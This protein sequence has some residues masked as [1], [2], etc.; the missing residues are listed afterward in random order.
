MK[1]LEEIYYKID[2]KMRVINILAFLFFPLQGIAQTIPPYPV[3]FVHGINSDGT[4]FKSMIADLDPSQSLTGGRLQAAQPTNPLNCW[5]TASWEKISPQSW[6]TLNQ[7]SI[8]SSKRYFAIDFS[9]NHNLTL[10]A[11]GRELKQVIECVKK[12]TSTTQSPTTK[13]IIVAHSMGGLAAREYL[14]GTARNE[15]GWVSYGDDVAKLITIGTPHQGSLLASL[16]QYAVV[17]FACAVLQGTQPNNVGMNSLR[18][19]SPELMSLNDVSIVQLP[20]SNYRSIIVR[21]TLVYGISDTNGDGVVLEDSQDLSLV[22]KFNQGSNH[23]SILTFISKYSCD[24]FQVHACETVSSDVKR[25]VASEINSQPPP[26]PTPFA[27]TLP[28][29]TV[30]ITSSQASLKGSVYPGQNAG[31]TTFSTRFQWGVTTS[32]EQTPTAW[33]N[34]SVSTFQGYVSEPVVGLAS[35]T[36]YYYRL[37]A[38]NSNGVSY[39]EVLSFTTSPGSS[40]VLPAPTLLSPLPLAWNQST[41]PILSWSKIDNALSYRIMVATDPRQLPTDKASATC[42]DCALNVT[43]TTLSYTPANG[44]LKPGALY[45]WQVKGRGATE[46]GN[47]SSSQAFATALAPTVPLAQPVLLSPVNGVTTST[48]TPT[49]TWS[50]VPDA[51]FYSVMVSSNPNDLTSPSNSLLCNLCAISDITYTPSYQT[52]VGQLVSGQTYYWQVKALNSTAVSS[53]S[54]PTGTF[55][56]G[57]TLQASSATC[58]SAA[59]ATY[60][61]AP[62]SNLC[63][64]GTPS[65]LTG[66]GPWWWSCSGNGQTQNCLANI[67]SYTIS[68]S[69]SGNGTISPSASTVNLGAFANFTVAPNVGSKASV[70][71]CGIDQG[72]ISSPTVVT[73]R[74]IASNCQLTVT[75]T[76]NPITRFSKICNSGQEAGQ[77]D[78]P[79]NPKLGSNPTDWACTRD[80]SNGLIWEVKTS[81]GG[82]RDKDKTYT[83]Y[84]IN[85][86]TN[87]GNA[88]VKNGG[89]CVGSRCDTSGYADS[90]AAIQLCGAND[91]R[92]PSVDEIVTLIDDVSAN[93]GLAAI[94]ATFFPNSLDAPYWTSSASLGDPAFAGEI[95]FYHDY[96]VGTYGKR[97]GLRLRSVRGSSLKGSTGLTVSVSGN[98]SVFSSPVGIACGSN[99]TLHADIGTS[100]TLSAVASSGYVF[101]GWSG[102]CVGVGATCTVTLGQY[103]EV[104]ALFTT[105]AV[106]GVCGSV[107]G[108]YVTSQPIFNLCSNGTPSA[109]TGSGPWNWSC[110]G[111]GGG[112]SATCS[113]Y[114]QSGG[115]QLP[116]LPVTGFAYATTSASKAFGI[117]AGSDGNIW[118]TEINVNRIGRITPSG[119][120][121]EFGTGISGG[122]APYG[123]TRGPDGNLWF[124]EFGTDRIGRITPTGE[125][126]EYQLAIGSSPLGIVAGSDGNLWYTAYN[127]VGRITTNGIVN[128]FPLP[129]GSNPQG[130]AAGA[131]GNL[132]F[133]EPSVDRIGRIT[134]NGAITEFGVGITPGSHPYGIT[135]GPD[136]NVWFTEAGASKIG[137]ITMTGVVTEY[138]I[139]S[140]A[141][142]I[143]TGSDNNLW[144]IENGLSRIGRMTP[145][146]V[147]AEFATSTGVSNDLTAGPDG[148]LW[149]TLSTSSVIGRISLSELKTTVTLG[150]IQPFAAQIGSTSAVQKVALSNTGSTT[151]H[152]ASIA[153]SGDFTQNGCSATIAPGTSCN[154]R[155]TFIPTALG[156]RIGSLTLV[157][158]AAGSPHTISL[159][160]TGTAALAPQVLLNTTSLLFTSQAIGT[161]SP[162]QLVTLTNV[163]NA[164]LTIST[165]TTNGDF[166]G[167]GS[168]G[169][170]TT[171][172]VLAVGQTCSI[173]V[174]FKP[175]AGGG[176]TGQVSVSSNAPGGVS[177]VSLAGAGD[178]IPQTIV[179]GAAPGIIAGGK[180]TVTATGGP[181][182]NAVVFSSATPALCT[183]AGN[184][185]SGVNPGNCVVVANQAG[186]NFYGAAAPVTQAISIPAAFQT[187]SFATGWN[188]VGQSYNVSFDVATI[189]GDPN[190]VLS[191]WKWNRDFT[192]P[193]NDSNWAFYSPSDNAMS[194]KKLAVYAAS[195]GYLPLIKI[196]GGDGYW[197]NAKIPFTVTLPTGKPVSVTDLRSLPKGWNL[198]ATGN[199]SAPTS[200]NAELSNIP[201]A[202]GVVPQNLTSLWVWDVTLSKWFFYSSKLESQGG[203]SLL[204]YVSSKG[205]V[206]FQSNG[207]TLAPGN[208]F[209]LNVP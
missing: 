8:S 186:N 32:L 79:G 145:T 37:V 117:T 45:W 85:P 61:S 78:C 159:V 207:K 146:G 55:V 44:I 185:V 164:P 43:T 119:V 65:A 189:F 123:I 166:S 87:G 118:F 20:Q 137:R 131:D 177:T 129:F 90:V 120:V 5:W 46:Y 203:S 84:D 27:T 6:N 194:M 103:R 182:G 121:T 10:S 140:T 173:S 116:T 142:T 115:T 107:N 22:S 64:A 181:S 99:C 7:N 28:P 180:G 72:W 110:I 92:I 188:L 83:W 128:E 81:D 204:D 34:W 63:S 187:L 80:N 24:G 11:Q 144:F 56:A 51:A 112:A 47:W 149:F 41:T 174:I 86:A 68:T 23:Q 105:L 179:F 3:I 38:S 21:Q 49:M 31:A 147:F 88:G 26:Q 158:D 94:D 134:P 190:K 163:G 148:N 178:L 209:W 127:K 201:P 30:N 69:V 77:G 60:L 141:T 151:L 52:P 205:F 138:N 136:G 161:S 16:C 124:T 62:T 170:P 35:N 42:D 122:A 104:T 66:T 58:G 206:D 208:G 109:V 199:Q 202:P 18:P 54:L 196:K 33:R 14:Q 167:V 183:V 100:V 108:Q 192:K 17:N 75:F 176:R 57:G 126:T 82:M 2:W 29:D 169:S 102:A 71:G 36:K 111:S 98:G 132:W 150:S 114:L 40:N 67:Q 39:G 74:Y 162:A 97:W 160:G 168:C 15:W 184:I 165:V 154:V 48:A 198:V 193:A 156:P 195:K 171:G 130:I 4:T 93:N 70:S 106:D 13:V 125:V 1:L 143:V 76:T 19:G 96:A 157:S 9:D 172:A 53:W 175:I 101:S 113:A 200:F 153:V 191:V 155:V 197:V 12:I 135:K 73:I 133:A 91:W 95:N 139:S 25:I 89:L 50:S 59:G 152:I